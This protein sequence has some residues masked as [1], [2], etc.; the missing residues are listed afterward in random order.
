MATAGV[1]PRIMGFGPAPAV[2]K[3]LAQTGL[4]WTRWTSSSSTKPSPPKAWPCC[5]TSAWPTTTRASI[6]TA[7]PSPWATRWA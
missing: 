7:A 1:P 5:A 4:T 3:V 2:R 6:P